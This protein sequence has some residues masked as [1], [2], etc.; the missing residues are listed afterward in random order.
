LPSKLASDVR[1][2]ITVSAIR[3]EIATWKKL[4]ECE[5]GKVAYTS[6]MHAGFTEA[7]NPRGVE[8]VQGILDLLHTNPARP[9]NSADPGWTDGQNS[10]LISAEAST[11]VKHAR[12]KIDEGEAKL[13]GRTSTGPQR[14]IGAPVIIPGKNRKRKQ[15]LHNGLE[16]RSPHPPP[17]PKR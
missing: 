7:E 6:A 15:G 17:F 1:A 4:E 3:K 13:Q 11:K 16:R 8:A 5:A 14:R 12:G 9:P 2:S 10:Y